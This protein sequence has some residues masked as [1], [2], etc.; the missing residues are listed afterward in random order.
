MP[1]YP[2]W[3]DEG[4]TP[5]YRF[6][7]PVD[8]EGGYDAGIMDVTD[9]PEEP[10]WGYT[11]ASFGTYPGGRLVDDFHPLRNDPQFQYDLQR[12]QQAAT[13]QPG[14]GWAQGDNAGDG[15]S[16]GSLFSNEFFLALA[17]IA[18]GA[19]L[20]SLTAAPAAGGAGAGTAGAAGAG[21]LATEG[22]LT[23]T[24]AEIAAGG[25]GLG[26]GA[27]SGIV[28]GSGGAASALGGAAGAGGAGGVSAGGFGAGSVATTGTGILGTGLTGAQ[29]L[30]LAPLAATGISALVTAADG[31]G[32]GGG[33]TG[34]S[35]ENEALFERLRQLAAGSIG[36]RLPG[37]LETKR[38]LTERANASPSALLDDLRDQIGTLRGQLQQRFQAAGKSLGP[39][40][41]RQSEREQGKLLASAGGQ[42]QK[43]FSDSIAPAGANLTNFLSSVRPGLM[44]ALPQPIVTQSNPDFSSLATGVKGAGQLY[45]AWNTPSALPA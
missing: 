23:A 40:G 3:A 11:T 9:V 44:T 26:A 12:W 30:K 21:T 17:A 22:G 5:K 10:D 29:L 18:G 1:R 37:I 39:S 33:S 24:A 25:G 7:R 38:E 8:S 45:R 42:L 28:G 27:T 6:V 4:Y 16:L 36:E 2:T 15:Y 41:G 35:A 14:S 32:G 13:G 20:A 43:M 34:T 31:G 19:G